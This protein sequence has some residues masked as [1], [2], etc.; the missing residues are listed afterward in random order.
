[1]DISKRK[2]IANITSSGAYVVNVWQD[3]LFYRQLAVC[4]EFS[5]G[6]DALRQARVRRIAA[7]LIYTRMMP[8]EALEVT[9]ALIGKPKNAYWVASQGYILLAPMFAKRA[10]LI[11]TP[12]HPQDESAQRIAA[13]LNFVEGMEIQDI[14][15]AYELS[16]LISS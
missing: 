4:D 16:K 2:Y 11:N 3:G 1:M 7:A 9:Q 13:A 12:Q 8:I 15:A 5:L 6:S 14:E 10:A